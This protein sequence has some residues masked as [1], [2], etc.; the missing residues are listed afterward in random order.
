MAKYVKFP[1]YRVPAGPGPLLRRYLFS[2][3]MSLVKMNGSWE[4]VV[5][6]YQG[7]LAEAENYYIGGYERELTDDEAADLP[8]EYVEE[9]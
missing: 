3:Q 9:R 7:T 4:P 1:T 8:A 2:R 5:T 6:P